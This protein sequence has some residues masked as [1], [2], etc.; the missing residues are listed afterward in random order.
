MCFTI[1]EINKYAFDINKY[2]YCLRMH[3]QNLF[4]KTAHLY[5]I[6]IFF[7]SKNKSIQTKIMPFSEK[8]VKNR[9]DVV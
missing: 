4:F 2:A 7:I 8:Y 1:R 5:E 6:N 3:T 9:G